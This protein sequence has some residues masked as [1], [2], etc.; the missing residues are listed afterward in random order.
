MKYLSLFLCLLVGWTS[1]SCAVGLEDCV[2]LG[3][4]KNPS[5]LAQKESLE[6]AA[7]QVKLAQA[8]YGPSLGLGG[9]VSQGF[10]PNTNTSYD[11]GLSLSQKLL[12]MVV[13]QPEVK[14][15]QALLAA[16][17]ATYL[18][19]LAQLR[20]DITAAYFD[21]VFAQKTL[22][23]TQKIATRRKTNAELVQSRYEAGRE[24]KGSYLRV[25]AQADQAALDVI[26]A[27][28]AIQVATLSLWRTIGA[29]A[30][31]PLSDSL[32]TPVLPPLSRLPEL[33]E[34]TPDVLAAQAKLDAAVQGIDVAQNRYGLM[35]SGSL[36]LDQSGGFSSGSS[37]SAS[38]K[39]SASFPLYTS[40]K[41]EADIETSI[42]AQTQ[43]D[44]VLNQTRLTL[45]NSLETSFLNAQN[46]QEN[47]AL[48][49]QFVGAAQT[50]SE[51]AQ[52]QY[53]SGLLSYDNWDLIENDLIAQQKNALNTAKQALLSVAKFDQLCGKG[54]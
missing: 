22:V 9:S 36:G 32:P 48:Q 53:S 14:Q 46:A 49:T 44:Q 18:G 1:T 17:R 24:H 47:A 45:K 12:P 6:S 35:V 21:V 39:L 3:F 37:T 7:L 27:K 26:Q 5:V 42:R 23:L 52:A 10:S 19:L 25:K 8:D 43:A 38:G 16:Q 20:Y 50:R 2:Q 4:T 30:E 41:K 54:L 51:I 11:A 15:A 40:G 34:K 13:S 33:A 29:T 31:G 28:R